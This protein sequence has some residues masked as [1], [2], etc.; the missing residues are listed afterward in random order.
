[1]EL[2]VRWIFGT[3]YLWPARE[4][5][6]QNESGGVCRP[7]ARGNALIGYASASDSLVNILP[8]IAVAPTNVGTFQNALWVAGDIVDTANVEPADGVPTGMNRRTVIR[9]GRRTADSRWSWTAKTIEYRTLD[10]SWHTVPRIAVDRENFV[11]IAHNMHNI[12]FQ[13]RRS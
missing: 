4:T 2:A 12:L 6:D 13:P 5:L 3:S 11:H 8:P 9:Q 1:L 7:D 10:S